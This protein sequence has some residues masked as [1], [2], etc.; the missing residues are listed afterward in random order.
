MNRLNGFTFI[1]LLVTIAILGILTTI[2]AVSFRGANKNARDTQRRA[3]IQE[4]KGG[5]EEYRLVSGVYPADNSSSQGF[6]LNDLQP[7]YLSRNY[8]DPLN[9]QQDGNN[10]YYY[11]E[12]VHASGCSYALYALMENDD[13]IQ[14]CPAECGVSLINVYCVSE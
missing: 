14:L 3:E 8:V 9:K 13:N 2:T 1:E 12:Y 11:Y 6:L 5:I 7:E 4:I 10:Y